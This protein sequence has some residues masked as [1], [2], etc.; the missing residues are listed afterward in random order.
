MANVMPNADW[1]KSFVSSGGI[2]GL[3]PPLTKREFELI[4]RERKAKVRRRSKKIN[5]LMF[6]YMRA[7]IHDEKD[8]VSLWETTLGYSADELR[9]HLERQ[10]DRRMTWSNYGVDGWHVDHI[11]PL[12]TFELDW[13]GCDEFKQAWALTNLRPL[14]KRDNF[15]KGQVR[16]HLV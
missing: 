1:L 14:W 6:K 7:A 12:T 5:R 15:R 10:F 2:Q 9:D 8:R 4:R 11:V 16:T 3:Q 13:F